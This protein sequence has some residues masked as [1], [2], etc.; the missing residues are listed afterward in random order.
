VKQ[1]FYRGPSIDVL[2]EEYAKQGRVDD[3][4]PVCTSHRVEIDAPVDTVWA[5]LSDPTRWPSWDPGI[6]D[7]ERADPTAVDARFKWSNG[8]SRMRSRFAVVEPGREIT[9]TGVA[10][11][12]KAVHR[13]VLT[14]NG[15]GTTTVISE[16]SM[17]GPLLSPVMSSTKLHAAME[18][19]LDALKRA[20]EED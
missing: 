13:N 4:A 8:R 16:E 7:V 2:H 20:A 19:W 18:E 3:R 14:A 15:S 5:L 10:A 11:G 6:H 1:L 12:A 9:W 17:A